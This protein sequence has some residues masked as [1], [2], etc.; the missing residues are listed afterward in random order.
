[1]RHGRWCRPASRHADE[2]TRKILASTYR[3]VSFG[4]G[5]ALLMPYDWIRR[6][7]RDMR[8]RKAIGELRKLTAAPANLGTFITAAVLLDGLDKDN[9]AV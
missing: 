1:M 3:A 4:L 2:L 6:K 5:R 8:A 9:E 7:T